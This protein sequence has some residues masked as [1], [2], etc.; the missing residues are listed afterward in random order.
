MTLPRQVI[1]FSLILFIWACKNQNIDSNTSAD[2]EAYAENSNPN[3]PFRGLITPAQYE[4]MLPLFQQNTNELEPKDNLEFEILE[5]ESQSANSHLKKHLSRLTKLTNSTLAQGY[6]FSMVVFREEESSAFERYPYLLTSDSMIKEKNPKA[7]LSVLCHEMAHA[8]RNHTAA[9]GGD[10]QNKVNEFVSN[11]LFPFVQA[12]FTD[13]RYI[14]RPNSIKAIKQAWMELGIESNAFEYAISELEADVMGATLCL[15]GGLS[16]DDF[17]YGITTAIPSLS[18]VEPVC[19][20]SEVDDECQF[21][22]D[23]IMASFFLIRGMA[24]FHHV[25]EA[26]QKNI[27]DLE[28][29]I[30]AAVTFVDHA[31]IA[32]FTDG[33][34]QLIEEV[35]FP[36]NSLNL[37]QHQDPLKHKKKK[38]FKFH[39]K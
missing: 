34:N 6:E 36:S 25:A 37:F 3:D 10:W 1:A 16:I 22:G 28:K 20:K 33:F 2:T 32:S 38:V 23:P 4:S 29:N 39:F 30:Q 11:T 8:F 35:N 5:S 17:I 27:K 21:Q 24:G 15:H 7:L 12:N 18:A 14:H 9:T 31:F 19:A 26:R 13:G